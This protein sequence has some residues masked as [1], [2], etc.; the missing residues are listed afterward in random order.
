MSNESTLIKKSKQELIDIINNLQ[1]ENAALKV[2]QSYIQTQNERLE[3]LEKSHYQNLQYQRR[4]TIEIAGIPDTIQQR[5]LEGE[6]VKIYEAAK[7]LVDGYKLASWQIQA[8][9]R[10]GKKGNTIVKFVNRKHAREGLFCGR[11]LKEANVYGNGTKIYINTS[12]CGEYRHINYLVRQ[13][14]KAN[15]IFR[16]KV[17]NGVNH[18]QLEEGGDFKEIGHKN[19]LIRL[20]LI[21]D[22]E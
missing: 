14:K 12:F 6:V 18:V 13:A 16:W 21:D 5:D 15:R 22:S 7:V 20:S 3:R 17:K 9:H 11:N 8:C 2:M 4:D 10:I 19:D 1:T